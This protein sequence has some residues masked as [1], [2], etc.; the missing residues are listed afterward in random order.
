MIVVMEG[1]A[2]DSATDAVMSFLVGTGCEV[3]RSSGENHTILG[4]VGTVGDD[5]VGV[6]EE[7]EGVL[8]VVQITEPYRLASRRFR[9]RS[10]V[11]SGE[12][13]TIG[14][15]T[16]WIAVEP[17]GLQVPEPSTD[18]PPSASLPYEVAAGRPFDAAVTRDRIAFEAVGALSCLSLHVS[19]SEAKFPTLFVAR[20]P[21]WGTEA[22]LGSAEKELQRGGSA[23]VLLET[24]GA[25]PG[26]A[27]TLDVAAVAN[28]KRRTHLPIVVDV[29]TIAERVSLVEP[30][31][32]AA[33]ASGA[34]GVI[35][36]AWVGT[37]AGRSRFAATL[38]WEAAMDLA[39]KLRALGDALNA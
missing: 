18:G 28:A 27:R 31:A 11:V 20:D 23:V 39:K 5:D 10:T 33:I 1:E 25:V 14:G 16:P 8:Q 9:R 2:P 7:F 21:S 4:V 30:V 34:D 32:C 37:E 36:R 17:I 24:G 19:P 38:S 29:P 3:H 6:I 35:L 12:W 13:G 15:N 22:W 26:G